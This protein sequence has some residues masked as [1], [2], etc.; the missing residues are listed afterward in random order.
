MRREPEKIVE[1]AKEVQKV[2]LRALDID[3][4]TPL[5]PAL[6]LGVEKMV[7]SLLSRMAARY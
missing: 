3:E 7:R 2:D 4:D 5:D 6:V 1:V